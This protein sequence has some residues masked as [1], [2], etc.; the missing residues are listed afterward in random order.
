MMPTFGEY[1]ETALRRLDL[2]LLE[3]AKRNIRVI[4]TLSNYWKFLGGMQKW[5]DAAY[6]GGLPMELFYTDEF[7]RNAYK[8]FAST[9][10]QRRNTLTGLS[11]TEDPTIFAYELANEPRTSHG[12]DALIGR[13]PGATICDWVAEMSAFVRS[14]DSNHLV[15]V[16]DEGMRA[17][18]PTRPGDE[19]A[20]LN[21][22]HEGADFICNLQYAD[23]ATTHIYP[24]SW[25]FGP[26]EYQWLGPNYLKDRRDIAWAQNKPIILEEYGMRR[27]YLQ[28]RD[29]YVL[30]SKARSF[31][32]S[33][34]HRTPGLD[35]M[36][37]LAHSFA[38]SPGTSLGSM[39]R[40]TVLDIRGHSSGQ[41]HTSPGR[42]M[43]T[44]TM[45]TMTGRGTF[46]A[47]LARTL[48]V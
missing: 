10:I 5:V 48:T 6:G 20:W 23:V 34:A 35:R 2:L 28:G 22:G 27:G 4:I 13:R 19:R 42:T 31:D 45:A 38:H 3:A 39:T 44:H 36:S 16:G 43:N 1:S 21:D 12:Y 30:D 15:T 11:Y 7:L 25:G 32:P 8:Q 46:S 41:S 24:D 47:S 40:S 14:L 37:R 9:I 29:E 17:D 18:V 26:T 33:I